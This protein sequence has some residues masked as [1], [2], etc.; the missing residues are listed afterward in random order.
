M[1]AMVEAEGE[2]TISCWTMR[3]T[4]VLS[5]ENLT[6]LTPLPCK[7]RG[8]SDSP[9]LPPLLRAGS[10]HC[11]ERKI[12][13]TDNLW[14]HGYQL[15]TWTINSVSRCDRKPG[16]RR[17]DLRLSR[18]DRKPGKRRADSRLSRCDRLRGKRRAD[19]RLSRCDRKP[20]KR[21]ADLRLSRCDR[22]P[23]KRRAD[24]RL[25]RCDRK[26]GSSNGLYWRRKKILSRS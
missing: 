26:P 8:E 22:K 20:G 1:M 6:P 17:A 4:G 7:G 12:I 15:K 5:K 23:G 10:I 9:L 16:K 14:R 11:D 21:R 24:L 3:G 18:C 2:L 13:L 25:S 19:S